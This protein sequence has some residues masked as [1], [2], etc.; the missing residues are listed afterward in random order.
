[1]PRRPS[2]TGRTK[3]E[4][5]EYR[6][7]RALAALPPT[8]QV[9]LS[10]RPPVRVDGQELEPEVQLTLALLERQG[11]AG[12]ETLSPAQAREQ[13]RR[14]ALAAE[15][16]TPEVGARRDLQ[17][18]GAE[19]LLAARLYSPGT[20]DGPDA[21][22][23]RALLVFFHGGGF[24]VGDLETHDEVCRLLCRHAGL[25]VLSVD[26]RLAPECPFPAAPLDGLAAFAWAV[27]HADEL[28]ADPERIGVGGDSAGGS[29]AAVVAQETLRRGIAAPAFQLLL[30]PATDASTEWPSVDRFAD[31]FFLT[32]AQMTWFREQYIRDA[33][34]HDPLLSP[35]LTSIDPA[36][37][38]ALIVTAGFDPLRD[39]GEAYATA[40]DAAGVPVVL[41]RFPGLIHGFA[42]MTGVSRV[43]RDAFL[44]VC[45]MVRALLRTTRAGRPASPM[46]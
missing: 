24:V 30:Y 5:L 1:M 3:R 32:R 44:E 7:A 33:D 18:D 31:G 40:L 6:A 27:A 9:K 8:T 25:H 26:Y 13:V 19:G 37:A 29:I 23:P 45:G 35:L 12:I 38:P 21:D 39:E 2:P 28:G 4:R 34:V 10:R 46:L 43:S 16:P 20:A 11:L 36:L 42:N 41:R 14:Q 17:V 15:G 22:A